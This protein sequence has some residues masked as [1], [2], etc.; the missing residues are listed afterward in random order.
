MSQIITQGYVGTNKLI[1]QGYS[2]AAALGGDS[3]HYYY[4]PKPQKKNNLEIFIQIKSLLEAL[5]GE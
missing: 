2:I 3:W 1:T 5:K 4:R